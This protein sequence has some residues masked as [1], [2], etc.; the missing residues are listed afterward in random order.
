VRLLLS[1]SGA[2]AIPIDNHNFSR[3]TR[4]SIDSTVEASLFCNTFLD[5]GQHE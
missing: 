3:K 1:R 5:H 2:N 4:F